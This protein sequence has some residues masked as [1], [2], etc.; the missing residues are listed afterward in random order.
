[1]IME[2]STWA[3]AHGSPPVRRMLP[4][5]GEHE[6]PLW[7][8][9]LDRPPPP[10]ASSQRR[11]LRRALRGPSPLDAHHVPPQ[12]HP[13][14]PCPQQNTHASAHTLLVWLGTFVRLAACVAV[15]TASLSAVPS[16]YTTGASVPATTH[17]SY[18]PQWH[19][20]YG[21]AHI[22]YL[23]TC[24][25]P[26]LW[27][28][29]PCYFIA[30]T[31]WHTLKTA[32][33]LVAKLTAYA[34]VCRHS[35]STF[36]FAGMMMSDEAKSFARSRTPHKAPP[37]PLPPDHSLYTDGDYRFIIMD[38]GCTTPILDDKSLFRSL[39]TS[40]AVVRAWQATKH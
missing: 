36:E 24:L 1:M 17:T 4:C 2:R 29:I 9:G 7:T 11:H 40:T 21:F 15:C 39:H 26:H 34:A 28:A 32:L 30:T 27:S 12:L 19:C 8:V 13:E 38:S 31:S 20:Q 33:W 35:D 5:I 25:L 14:Y 16:V 10:S 6:Y 22:V 23:L 3:P 37:I 18:S